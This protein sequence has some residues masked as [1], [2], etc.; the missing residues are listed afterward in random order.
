MPFRSRSTGAPGEELDYVEITAPV[1]PVAASEATANVVVTGNAI[2][3]DGGPVMVEFFSPAV[4]A[5]P[6]AG[7]TITLVLYMDGVALDGNIGLV[8][9]AA[10]TQADVPVNSRRRT[11][12]APGAH[13]FSVRAFVSA[14]TGNVDAGAGG[15]GNSVPA[16][17]RVTRA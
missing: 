1:A 13:T 5:D 12:P 7:R 8:K 14:G 9:A 3:C 15:T 10:A 2:T 11:T 17:I 4:R 16:F 6:T